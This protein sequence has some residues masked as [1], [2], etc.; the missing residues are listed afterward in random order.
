[1]SNPPIV[2][3]KTWCDIIN[4]AEDK[5]TKEHAQTMILG[6]FETPVDMMLFLE[7]HNLSCKLHG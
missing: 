6:A 7:K 4:N 5:D 3:V 1:M 2:L